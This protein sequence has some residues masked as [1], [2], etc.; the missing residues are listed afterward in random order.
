[1]S[2][3]AGSPK[4]KPKSI[5]IDTSAI[6]SATT[7]E[8]T[9]Q[10]Q[11]P[12]ENRAMKAIIGIALL[13]VGPTLVFQGVGDTASCVF[14]FGLMGLGLSLIAQS[15][16]SSRVSGVQAVSYFIISVFL[17]FFTFLGLLIFA[18]SSLF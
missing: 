2:K 12:N 13:I 3:P 14:C 16:R 18:L 8:I 15:F 4:D 1:M 6:S 11:K 9:I 17:V 7:Q 10:L 5:V